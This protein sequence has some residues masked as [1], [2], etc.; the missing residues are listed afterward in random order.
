MNRVYNKSEHGSGLTNYE[1]GSYSISNDGSTRWYDKEGNPHRGD[2]LPAVIGPGKLTHYHRG[3]LHRI[4]GPALIRQIGSD[5]VYTWYVD[6]K[7]ITSW[8]QF[9]DMSGVPLEEV[10]LKVLSGDWPPTP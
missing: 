5:K 3:K 6:N 2:G 8:E 1:N 10:M 4:D 9:S 7:R